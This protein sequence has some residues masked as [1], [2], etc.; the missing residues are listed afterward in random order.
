MKLLKHDVRMRWMGPG[1]HIM[2]YPIKKNTVYNMVL[3]HPQKPISDSASEDAESWANK[4]YRKEMM[5]LYKDLNSIVKDL[6]SYVPEGE[7][8]K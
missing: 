6:L 2:A 7:V 8:M 4:G 3:L 1:G 5:D